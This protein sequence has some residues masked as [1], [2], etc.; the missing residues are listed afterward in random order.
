[1]TFATV[2][3]TIFPLRSIRRKNKPEKKYLYNTTV[4]EIP[5]APVSHTM[6][7]P[8]IFVSVDV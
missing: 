2:C 4:C 1:M 6:K 3:A 7:A 5:S 8:G